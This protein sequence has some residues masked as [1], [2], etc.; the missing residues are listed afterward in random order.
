MYVPMTMKLQKIYRHPVKGLTPEQ[1]ESV[2][3]IADAAMPNDRRFAIALGST[4]VS[5]ATAEWMPKSSF[6]M[7]MK[8]EKLAQLETSFDDT[9]DTLTIRRGGNQ[10]ARGVLSQKIG[11]TMIE[12]FFAAFMKDEARGRPKLVEVTEGHVLSDHNNPVVSIINEASVK[13]L[14]RVVGKEIDPRR[15]RGNLLVDGIEPWSEFNLCGNQIKIG[16]AVLEVTVPIDRCGATNV[17]P[18]TAERDL[19][20]PKDLQRGYGHIDCGVYARVVKGGKISAGLEFN[21]S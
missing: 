16:D 2:M 5:G 3:L 19:N 10:V 8:N 14:E 20:L 11:R 18:V 9:S 6:L 17:N 21:I 7:L 1:L 12:D 15:F 13:D 4:P